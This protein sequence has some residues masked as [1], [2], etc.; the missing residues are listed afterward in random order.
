VASKA[1]HSA[2]TIVD[3]SGATA[4]ISGQVLTATG[5]TAATWQSPAA[6]IKWLG[7]W[8]SQ[9]YALNDAVS[10]QGG[11]YICKLATTTS[12]VPTNTTYWDV[13]VLSASG[14]VFGT[15]YQTSEMTANT[16]TTA[17][18]MQTRQTFTST[19]LP[20]G[21]YR[22]EF[23]TIQRTNSTSSSVGVTMLANSTPLFGGYVFASQ[24]SNTN[25]NM[26]NTYSGAD[27][28]SLTSQGTIDMVLQYCTRVG[29]GTSF[30]YYS[31]ITLWRVI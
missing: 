19:T 23:I 28:F 12:Q 13:A 17:T 30:L 26:R 27:Y 5:G 14:G 16:S 15:E 22:I 25:G 6:C 11:F 7:E 10:Y 18:S 8:A 24:T 9:N 1:L 3:V 31:R 2:T 21:T 29:S 4:P 20:A